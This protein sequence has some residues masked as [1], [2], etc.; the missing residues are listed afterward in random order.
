MTQEN[1]TR[2]YAFNFKKVKEADFFDGPEDPRRSDSS[3]LS[4]FEVIT[5]EKG[6]HYKRKTESWD[7]QLPS[8]IAQLGDD[9][10]PAVESMVLNALAL[11]CKITYVDNFEPVG[12]HSLATY[13]AWLASRGGRA[14]SSYE[15]DKETLEA[16]ADSIGKYLAE[17]TGSA[18]VGEKFRAVAFAKF[19][20]SSI[21][22]NLGAFSTDLV[23]RILTRVDA[24]AQ[25][26]SEHQSEDA[27]D[28]APVYA[29]YVNILE[30]H[31]RQD[32]VNVAKL[33]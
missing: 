18:T 5:D 7:I 12:D 33:I 1:L 2:P 15:Y 26:V 6:T 11:Y 9:E 19:T 10:R 30:K 14:S 4:K 8:F 13:S 22:R 27:D 16:A 31:M 20:R 23:G 17:Q 32:P 29:H 3:Y 25:F 21:T 24:W 28:F